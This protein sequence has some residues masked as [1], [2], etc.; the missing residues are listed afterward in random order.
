MALVFESD[1]YRS[2]PARPGTHALVVG[3][4]EY[5]YLLG[6][7][8][9]RQEVVGELAL[10]Q[11]TS[12]PASARAV[13][14]WLLG[15]GA[16]AGVANAGL[17]NPAAPLATVDVLL[18]AADDHT[19][20]PSAERLVSAILDWKDRCD[21][22]EANVAF[23][24]VCGHGLQ[25]TDLVLL[26]S[27]FGDPHHRGNLWKGALSLDSI[28]QGMAKC[29]ARQ[30]F[31]FFDCCRAYQTQLRV[32]VATGVQAFDDLVDDP[33][34]HHIAA[35]ATLEGEYAFGAIHQPSYFTA[36]L[37]DGLSGFG[38]EP[39]N[40]GWEV[41]N[42]SLSRALHK[43]MEFDTKTTPNRQMVEGRLTG[44]AVLHRL[45]ER[46]KVKLR[47]ECQPAHRM[48][49]ATFSITCAAESYTHRGQDG[50][51]TSLISPGEW[52]FELRHDDAN[53]SPQHDLVLCVPPT[54]PKLFQV[55]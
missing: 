33:R 14:D 22:S 24:Y 10:K 15:T 48:G 37:L 6:G 25:L 40:G 32:R 20:V 5:P 11:L 8:H 46:P 27:D 36:A 49:G 54:F 41:T 34:R 29:K 19:D 28:H 42:G 44:D 47:V 26:A 39:G 16:F 23:L 17:H 38:S 21:T 3:I 13:R 1:A 45:R 50:P 43:L 30:Q 55:V 35:Y 31:L 4:G 9:E 7:S 2:D 51:F 12:S 52:A 53:L 18:S